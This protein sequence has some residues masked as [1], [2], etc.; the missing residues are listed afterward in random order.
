MLT[1][2]FAG[3]F[4]FMLALIGLISTI[5]EIGRF[6]QAHFNYKKDIHFKDKDVEL[7]S[8]AFA[9]IGEVKKGT[10]NELLLNAQNIQNNQEI[11]AQ[12]KKQK[13]FE[14]RLKTIE[15]RFDAIEKRLKNG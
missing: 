15:T 12:D 6:I 11:F 5:N 10:H 7:V 3:P 2:N 8:E 1:I 4:I 14:S 13:K 9:K